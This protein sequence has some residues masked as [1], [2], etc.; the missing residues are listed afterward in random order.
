MSDTITSLA[1]ERNDTNIVLR[2][3]LSENYDEVFIIGVKDGRIVTTTSGY[4]DFER[5]IGAL[6]MLKMQLLL[7]ATP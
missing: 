2:N 4:N 1:N 6:E 7:E 3:A 5:K